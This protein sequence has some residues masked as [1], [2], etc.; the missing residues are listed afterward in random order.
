MHAALAGLVLFAAAP[1]PGTET[2]R[3]DAAASRA[4]FEVRVLLVKRIGG[5]F[6]HVE[7]SIARD[8]QAGSFDVDV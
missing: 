4:S 5:D 7:G 8:R 1:A 2:L 6:A 3:I